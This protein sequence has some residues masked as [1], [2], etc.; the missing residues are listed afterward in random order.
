MI[1]NEDDDRPR[2]PARCPRRVEYDVKSKFARA[3]IDD[4]I[5][6]RLGVRRVRQDLALPHASSPCSRSGSTRSPREAP[7]DADERRR[8]RRFGAGSR[9][10]K[11]AE[12][13]ARAAHDLME[14][15][16]ERAAPDQSTTDHS[17]PHAYGDTRAGTAARSWPIA[18]RRRRRRDRTVRGGGRA[19]RRSPRDRATRARGD[20]STRRA[21][22][23]T[24]S[25]ATAANRLAKS[26][27]R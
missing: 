9:V 22:R 2:R 21:R 1:A 27:P 5:E 16:H 12:H 13:R 8:V 15:P 25:R 14:L 26:A 18:S 10:G 11:Q 3:R 19:S 20:R 23:S 4:P 7:V 24:G 6:D 17:A